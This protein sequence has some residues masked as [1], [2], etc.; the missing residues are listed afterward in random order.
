[1]LPLSVRLYT[2]V[3]IG[4]LAIAAIAL[5]G[6]LALTAAGRPAPSIAEDALKMAGPGLLGLLVAPAPSSSIPP[7]PSSAADQAAARTPGSKSAA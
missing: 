1:M 2:I 4:L 5:V 7:A 3:A 6:S